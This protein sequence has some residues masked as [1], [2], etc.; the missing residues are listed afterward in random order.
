MGRVMSALDLAR[1]VSIESV[2]RARGIKLK[3]Q[4]K[5]KKWMVGP[6][7]RCGGTDRFCVNIIKQLWNCRHCRKGGD[8]IDL[9]VHLDEC[10]VGQAIATLTGTA[11]RPSA[12]PPPPRTAPAASMDDDAEGM[13]RALRVWREAAPLR[14]PTSALALS[15]LTRP[16]AKDGRGLVLP[17]DLLSGGV[18]RFHPRHWWRGEDGEPIQMPALLAL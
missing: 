5:N 16:R 9:V 3:H 4:G 8:V 10:T 12:S 2:V 18:L 11:P 7:P 6:C 15:Y 1:A 14:A 17:D 13:R